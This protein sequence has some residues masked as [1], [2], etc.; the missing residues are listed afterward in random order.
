MVKLGT[1]NTVENL[2]IFLEDVYQNYDEECEENTDDEFDYN[3]SWY[4]CLVNDVCVD[5]KI[6]P[7]ALDFNTLYSSILRELMFETIKTPDELYTRLMDFATDRDNKKMRL[8][9]TCLKFADDSGLRHVLD[10]SDGLDVFVSALRTFIKFD[11]APIQAV[12]LALKSENI[13]YKTFL[14]SLI[15]SSYGKIYSEKPVDDDEL[16]KIVDFIK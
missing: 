7:T 14:L 11:N 5:K 15:G 16:D 4:N 3:N 8:L 10:M 6:N 9:F 2:K 1:K 12:E 13:L